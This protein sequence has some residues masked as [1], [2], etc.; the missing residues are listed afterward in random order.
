MYVVVHRNLCHCSMDHPEWL[1]PAGSCNRLDSN[2]I[3][4]QTR[5]TY[6][7]QLTGKEEVAEENGRLTFS[8]RIAAFEQKEP[9]QL[10]DGGNGFR[11]M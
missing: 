2:E 7:K 10:F 6:S 4:S 9:L 1:D 8:F 3:Y 11:K 5:R